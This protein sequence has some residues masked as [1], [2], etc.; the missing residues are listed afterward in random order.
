MNTNVRTD[1]TI[2]EGCLCNKEQLESSIS[3]ACPISGSVCAQRGT[4][5]SWPRDDAEGS[6]TVTVSVDEHLQ[7]GVIAECGTMIGLKFFF[8]R[9]VNREIKERNH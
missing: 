1:S 7:G 2:S 5:I 9:V 4:F 6:E 8:S 3:L